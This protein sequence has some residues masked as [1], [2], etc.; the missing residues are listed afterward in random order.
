MLY[1]TTYN[2]LLVVINI[3]VGIVAPINSRLGEIGNLADVLLVSIIL[4][5]NL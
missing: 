5:T 3:C 4:K 1:F 2:G